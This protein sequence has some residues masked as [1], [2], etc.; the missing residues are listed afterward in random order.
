MPKKILI[1]DDHADLR[2]LI[3]IT[4]LGTDHALSEAATGD[5]A[6]VRI[7]EDRPDLV[8]LDVMMPGDLN[9]YQVCSRIKNDPELRGTTVILVTARAQAA[10]IEQGEAAGADMYL[11][12][13]FSPMQLL[14]KV[15]TALG[16]D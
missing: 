15:T 2:K 11:I 1:V 6:M 12:K 5:E 7:R 3:R 13:P 9:G 14:E 8:I 10:D 16:D 4:L